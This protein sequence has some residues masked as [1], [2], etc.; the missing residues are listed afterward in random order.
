MLRNQA[1]EGPAGIDRSVEELTAAITVSCRQ[2]LRPR[3][4]QNVRAPV[5]WCTRLATYKIYPLLPVISTAS[6]T[7]FVHD[8][9]YLTTFTRKWFNYTTTNSS[10]TSLLQRNV[11]LRKFRKARTCALIFGTENS[12]KSTNY[13]AALCAQL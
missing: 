11:I 2:C 9:A 4:V 12:S 10:Y 5:F 3:R 6:L 7:Y 13:S 1:G 8:I